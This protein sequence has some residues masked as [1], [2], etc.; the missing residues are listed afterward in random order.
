MARAYP[1]LREKINKE[2]K[3]KRSEK[4]TTMLTALVVV[5]LGLALPAQGEL[6]LI[7][8][9]SDDTY[10]GAS[11][12]NPDVNG[13]YWNSV[14][15]GYIPGLL[16]AG[17]NPT[18]LAYAPDGVGGTDFYNG[19]SGD[20]EDPAA[21][22]YNAAALGDLG[23]DEA[24]YDYFVNGA[25][26]IQGLD[27]T[28]TYNLTIYGSHKY[29]TPGIATYEIH[30]D[31]N[32]TNV[33]ASTT[34]ETNDEPINGQEWMHNQD[35]VTT[36]TGVAPQAFDILYLKYD[37]HINAMSIEAIPEPATIGL[38]GVFGAAM[39]VLRKKTRI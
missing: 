28:K 37:G 25:F 7:D 33:V 21:S 1:A 27:N 32:Y 14:G 30:N 3:M 18:S 6:V 10:R 22:V 9:S 17:G 8:L 15:Y 36:I 38:V 16:D 35:R 5:G 29:D 39:F 24:V 20:T 23:V 26:Q 13:N 31:S 2:K 12:V 4:M 34:L 11:V 19:P